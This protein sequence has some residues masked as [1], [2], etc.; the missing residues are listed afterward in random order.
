MLYVDT[1]TCGF[2]GPIVTIQTGDGDDYSEV[3]HVWRESAKETLSLI[4]GLLDDTI[5][6]YNASFD[7]FHLHKLYN[8]LA[9]V[10]DCNLPPI[11]QEV[12]AIERNLIQPGNKFCLRP[13]RCID[14]FLILRS[15]IYQYLCSRK[16]IIIRDVPE[17]IVPALQQFLEKFVS[18]HIPSLMFARFKNKVQGNYWTISPSGNAGFVNLTLE[19]APTQ[20]LKPVTSYHFKIKTRKFSEN[21]PFINE[22][23]YFPF[24][25]AWTS[26]ISQY[27]KYWAEDENAIKYAHDDIKFLQM[28]VKELGIDETT[29]DINSELAWMVGGV[30]FHGFSLDTNKLTIAL[31]KISNQNVPIAPREALRYIKDDITNPLLSASIQ[32]TNKT[33]LEA[34]IREGNVRAKEI[35]DARR[36]VKQKELLQKLNFAGRFFPDFNVVGTT[37]NRMSGRSG[38]NPQGISKDQ[39]IRS[40]FTFADEGFTLCAGDFDAQ[41]VTIAD[42]IYNDPKLR[43]SLQSGQKIHRIFASLVFSKPQNEINDKEYFIGKTCVFAMIYGGGIDRIAK[44]AGITIEHAQKVYDEF[45]KLYP[46]VAEGRKKVFDAFCSMR[47]PGGIGSAVIW[48]NPARY[49]NSLFGFKRD[50]IIYNLFSKFLFELATNLPIKDNTK[51]ERR[52]RQQTVSGATK[53]ALYGTAF[54]LQSKNMSAACNHE[55]QATGASIT[56]LLQFSLYKE[57]QPIGVHPFNVVLVNVH[58]EVIAAVRNSIV[59]DVNKTVN[60]TIHNLQSVVPL[61]KLQWKTNLNSWA[62]K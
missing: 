46:K 50:F 23:E 12:A 15:T 55:I 53:T 44:V 24:S 20:A 42:A 10:K 52:K 56:K 22:I 4:E 37:S 34:L 41:E 11:I 30:R 47:Q 29:T 2:T 43:E 6:L 5:V 3:H 7:S 9:R 21:L 1:E 40:I 25:A 28:W 16:P 62:D 45:T 60:T 58:D 54:N 17:Q 8:I 59:E 19:F 31:N 49:A 32:N 18:D 38:L 36:L 57:H 48:A 61:L 27:I 26:N 14:I 35:Y 51:V 39:N 13:K 33:T